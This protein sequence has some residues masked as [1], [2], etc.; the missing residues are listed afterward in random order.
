MLNYMIF[1]Y[2]NFQTSTASTLSD[3][4]GFYQLRV[5]SIK[6]MSFKDFKVVESIGKGSFA[7]VYKVSAS[8]EST[9]RSFLQIGGQKV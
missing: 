8:V 1:P 5:H 7:S 9:F 3:V 6:N 2:S 4:V